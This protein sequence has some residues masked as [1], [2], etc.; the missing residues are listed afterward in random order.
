MRILF[1]SLG[2]HGHVYPLIPLARAARAAGHEVR[3]ATAEVMHPSLAL[4]GIEAVPAGLSIMEAV[5]RVVGGRAPTE[6]TEEDRGR[7][8]ETVFGS[9]LPKAFAADVV[10]IIDEFTPELMVTEVGNVGA[11]SAAAGAGVPEIRHGFGRASTEFA[12]EVAGL[13]DTVTA[14]LGTEFARTGYRYV[15]VCPLSLQN[16]E[17]LDT[18]RRVAL[19]P[20]PYAEPGELPAI[21]TGT[22]A[23]LVYLTL[24][25][26][27]G[28]PEVLREAIAGLSTVDARVLVAAGPQVDVRALGSVPSTVQV[29]PWVPQASV[30]PH[31]DL[32]VHHG[33]S[34]TTLGA[35]GASVPQILVPQGA[36]QFQ[37]AELVL[38]VGAG[39]RLLPE[40]FDASALAAEVRNVLAEPSYRKASGTIAAEIAAMPSPA[41]VAARLPEFVD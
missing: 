22:G 5:G 6:L 34:G 37:N 13:V 3:W 35:F 2:S 9:V 30:L 4:A 39:T 40:E 23:P 41:E 19:R 10:R 15:D 8:S 36:D 16:T 26:S 38:S 18:V 1:S 7:V 33:G 21:V 11:T 32:V 17:F 14:E 24:G 20:V 31:L 28:N 12:H 29:L 25:T 27:F